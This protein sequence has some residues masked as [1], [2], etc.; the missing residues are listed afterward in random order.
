MRWTVMGMLW[1]DVRK[2]YPGQFVYLEDLQSHIQDG[3]LYVEEVAVIRPLV[4][5]KEALRALKSASGNRFI[6]H[7]ANERVVMDVVMKPMVRSVHS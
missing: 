3:K 6:Y 5:S 7:T 4:D 1:A 2:L